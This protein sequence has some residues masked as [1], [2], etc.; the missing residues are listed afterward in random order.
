MF[1][2]RVP[3]FYEE[4]SK[5]IQAE[6]ALAK[7]GT[8]EYK[9]LMSDLEALRKFTGEEKEMKQFFDKPGRA[10]LIGKLIG[11]IG[12]GGLIFGLTKFEKVDGNMFSGSNG[13]MKGGLLKAAF[14]LF[15]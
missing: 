4:E 10:S 5:R 1:R 3:T 14:K 2:K 13:E 7:P 9:K 6:L 8:D 12:I 11:F 15:G